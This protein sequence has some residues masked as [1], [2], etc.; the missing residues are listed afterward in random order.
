MPAPP[1]PNDWDVRFRHWFHQRDDH[2]GPE[3][4]TNGFS[5]QQIQ[6]ARLLSELGNILVTKNPFARLADEEEMA[7]LA[8]KYDVPLSMVRSLERFLRRAPADLRN[9]ARVAGPED[10]DPLS[11]VRVTLLFEDLAREEGV[12]GQLTLEWMPPCSPGSRSIFPRREMRMIDQDEKWMGAIRRAFESLLSLF[13]SKGCDVRW[14]VRLRDSGRGGI[15]SLRGDSAGGAFQYA[16]HSLLKREEPI[17]GVAF[18]CKIA[19][20][21]IG[22]EPVGGIFPKFA[23]VAAR[24]SLPAIHTVVAAKDQNLGGVVDGF[25]EGTSRGDAKIWRSKEGAFGRL[26]IIQA[27]DFDVALSAVRG[28]VASRWKLAG[29]EPATDRG[30]LDRMALPHQVH[31]ASFISR[32]EAQL[33]TIDEGVLLITGEMGRGK[34]VAMAQ[35]I[36]A[37]REM[38]R[39]PVCHFIPASEGNNLRRPDEIVR[40]LYTQLCIRHNFSEPPEWKD[41]Y[42]GRPA[43]QLDALLTLIS[44]DL[45]EK[46]EKEVIVIEA[47]DQAVLDDGRSLLPGIFCIGHPRIV[48]LVS[49]RPKT[50]PSINPVSSELAKSLIHLE[51]GDLVD[52]AKDARSLLEARGGR[53]DPPLSRELIDAICGETDTPPVMFTIDWCLRQLEPARKSGGNSIVS[54][55]TVQSLREEARNWLREPRDLVYNDLAAVLHRAKNDHHIEMEAARRWLLLTVL[56][57]DLTPGL[58]GSLGLWSDE[59]E[60]VFDLAANFFESPERL[61]LRHPGYARAIRGEEIPSPEERIL[62]ERAIRYLQLPPGTLPS[63]HRAIANACLQH[64]NGPA[65]EWQGLIADVAAN[66]GKRFSDREAAALFCIR[67]IVHHFKGAGMGEEWARLL[68]ENPE[69]LFRRVET[70]SASDL[71]D[72]FPDE[73]EAKQLGL[74]DDTARALGSIRGVIG[75]RGHFIDQAREEERMQVEQKRTETAAN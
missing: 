66:P 64:W 27:P 25:E 73:W 35:L 44:A 1:S 48:W 57:Q 61:V 59:S 17:P 32:I 54:P 26:T 12:C 37:W 38:G 28:D 42:A 6:Q 47:A 19:A 60:T 58:L 49:S 8:K 7:P 21:R 34:T 4:D 62:T 40:H 68:L 29:W 20:D 23:A 3:P 36:R 24:P 72:D 11:T 13:P 39:S 5:P 56:I 31:R 2:R 55:E 51:F 16:L 70:G 41:A 33:Q 46:G 9:V 18:S 50:A 67:R 53:L 43:D 52:D 69:F 22:F 74:A 45:V 71:F 30:A 15:S 14:T 63:A 75:R 65:D 10:I